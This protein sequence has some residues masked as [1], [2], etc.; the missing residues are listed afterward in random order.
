MIGQLGARRPTGSEAALAVGVVSALLQLGPVLGQGFVLIRD[1]VFVP[2]LP[3]DAHLLGVDSVPR[4]VPSDLLVALASRVLPG[5]VVEDLVLVAVIAMAGWGA[6][7]LAAAIRPDRV[8]AAASAAALFS[9]NPYLAERLRQGQW[10]ILVGYAALP[11]VAASALALHRGASRSGR[12]LFLALVVAAAG[13]ASAELL[14]VPVAVAIVF[15][16]GSVVGWRRRGVVVL[17]SVAVVSLPWAVPGLTS[18]ST[19]TPDRAGVQAFAARPDTPFGTLGSL[20]SLGGIWNAQ[21]SLPGRG[22]L[23]VAGLAIALTAVSLWAFWRSRPEPAWNGL[24]VAGAASLLVSMWAATPGLRRLAIDLGSTSTTG[25]LLRDGQRWLAPFVLLVAVGFGW[26]AAWAL[27]RVR[28][29]AALPLVPL[30][31]LP[32]AAWGS[33]GVLAAVHWPAAWPAVAAASAP[34]PPGPVLVLPWSAQRQFGWNG[35]R[36]LTDPAA[37]WLPRR[38]VGDDSLRVGALTTPLEDP[39]A[40]SIAAAATG[41]GPLLP[42]LQRQGYAAVLVER[43]QPGALAAVARLG[44]LRPVVVTQTLALYAV[45]GA[46]RRSSPTAPVGL[47]LAADALVALVL[48]MVLASLADIRTRR[49]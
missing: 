30:L 12:R 34:L 1:M 27:A 11:W 35:G 23:L 7:R 21:V 49:A 22:T 8:L 29:A 26:F 19:Y 33:D 5:M 10:A 13:G 17:A 14:A 25:G 36:V 2:R 48:L 38:V 43:D 32:A 4:A 15:W 39:L 46:A 16:P 6:G 44:G 3:L 24:L 20:L 18:P 31:L 37:H 45:P 41:T 28:V 40:R 9:W 42:V 47:T